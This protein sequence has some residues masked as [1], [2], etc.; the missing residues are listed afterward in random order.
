MPTNEYHIDITDKDSVAPQLLSSASGQSINQIKL[1]MQKG[2]V[3]LTDDK[4]TRRI[5][6]A[7]KNLANGTRLHFYHNPEVLEFEADKPQLL[8]D[9]QAY[10]IWVKPRGVLSQG[11]KWGDHCAITRQ[12]EMNDP[13]QR[14]AFLIHRLDRAAIGL[15]LIGHSKEATKLLTALFAKRA[16]Q[17]IYQAI[18]EGQFNPLDEGVR[19]DSNIDGRSAITHAR[20]MSY[21]KKNNRSLVELS[22]ETGRKHQIRKH[23][24][25][26]GFPI[27]G[28]RLYGGGD[29][30]DLQLAAVSLAFQCPI[31][32]IPQSYHLPDQLG[33]AF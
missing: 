15:M 19:F 21:N 3:W 13:K 14:P 11:S 31:N 9:E 29:Q 28:D 7:K 33:P 10:S 5:R 2:A 24:S 32:D 25:E 16:I 6:R 27:L 12:I 23:L 22:I 20:L 30:L 17:K 4:G 18:V 8:A 1:A 26:A